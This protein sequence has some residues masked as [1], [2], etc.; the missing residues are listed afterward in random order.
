MV[1]MAAPMA[2]PMKR[3]RLSRAQAKASSRP[4]FAL[5]I[6]G[7]TWREHLLDRQRRHHRRP[8]FHHRLRVLGDVVRGREESGMTCDAAH[9]PRGGIVHDAT[10]H[11][12]T[13]IFAFEGKIQRDTGLN[14]LRSE[15][16]TSE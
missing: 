8:A 11:G 15:E 10:Q 1:L 9:A 2:A 4:T 14:I 16:H 7:V 5:L 6:T 13:L 3:S 12:A